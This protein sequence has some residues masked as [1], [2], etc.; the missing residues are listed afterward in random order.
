MTRS[1]AVLLAAGLAVLPALA[2]EFRT[3]ATAT[4]LYDAP[5]PRGKKL[6]VIKRDTPVELV[7]LLEGWAKV[8]D[9]EGGMAWLESKYL[10]MRHSVVVTAPRAQIRQ[11]ADESADLVFE[12]ERNV[13]LDYLEAA[14]SGWVKV[15]HRDGASGYVRADQIWGL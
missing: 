2:V 14:A 7:V 6:F 12:A 15:R 11:S 1:L 10:A 9:S 3:V 8:R 5:S 4:V 13:A